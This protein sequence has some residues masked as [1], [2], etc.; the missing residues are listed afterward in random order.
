MVRVDYIYVERNIIYVID[1]WGSTWSIIPDWIEQD[2]VVL[3]L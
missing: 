1:E 2:E 3:F